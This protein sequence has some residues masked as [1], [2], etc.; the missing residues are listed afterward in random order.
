MDHDAT[1]EQLELAALEPGGLERLMAGDTAAAQAVAAHLA[2]CSSCTDELARLQGAAELIRQAV[3]EMPPADLRERTL[4]AVRAE[5]V[6][7]PLSAVARPAEA[8]PVPIAEPRRIRPVI[9][10]IATVAAAVVLSVVTTSLVVGSRVDE[11]LAGQ[12]ETISALEE[13]T[14]ATL[15]ITAQPDAQHV[16]LVGVGDPALGGSLVYSPSTTE[17]VVVATGL[18]DP[19]AGL[20]YRCWV[21]VGGTRQRVGRMFFSGHLAYWVGPASAVAGVSDGAKFGVSLVGAAGPA[22]DT[23]PVL[24]GSL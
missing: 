16:A 17:L 24:V 7:R 3:R 15:Q 13:V 4:A 2:G 11:R 5:G 6:A 23:A 1:R 18:K 19:S 10:W 21:E 12:A 8:A 20:E 9:G 14:T 22:I